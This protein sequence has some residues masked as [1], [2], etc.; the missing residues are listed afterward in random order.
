MATRNENDV[1][2][3]VNAYHPVK[4]KRQVGILQLLF[5]WITFSDGTKVSETKTDWTILDKYK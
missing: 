4:E 3:K 1:K 5:G 2:I